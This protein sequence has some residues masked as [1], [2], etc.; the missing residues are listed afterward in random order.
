MFTR[1]ENTKLTQL[2]ELWG[3]LCI[4]QLSHAQVRMAYVRYEQNRVFH[5]RKEQTLKAIDVTSFMQHFQFHE[6]EPNLSY[7][8]S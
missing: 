4:T 8:T 2:F 1:L 3:F 7:T 6:Q 5:L